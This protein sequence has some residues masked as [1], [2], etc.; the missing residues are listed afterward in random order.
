MKVETGVRDELAYLIIW[1]HRL[2]M[3]RDEDGELLL[4]WLLGHYRTTPYRRHT[5]WLTSIEPRYWPDVCSGCGASFGLTAGVECVEA[6]QSA[7]IPETGSCYS[8]GDAIVESTYT[9]LS[10]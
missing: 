1:Y 7:A 8:H 9:V 2:P 3:G 6:V 5:P 10:S 4:N